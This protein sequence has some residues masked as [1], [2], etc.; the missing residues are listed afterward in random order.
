MLRLALICF[1]VGLLVSWY[2]VQPA[3]VLE[4][5]VRVTDAAKVVI[6][7]IKAGKEFRYGVFFVKNETV[8]DLES[9][10]SRTSTYNDYLKNLKVVK[11]TGKECRYGVL[12]FEFQ[13]KSSAD[14]KRD[15]LVLMSWCPDDVKVRSKFIHAASVEGM[16]KAVT[17]ISAFVQA[18]DDEQASLVEVQDKLTRTV[19]AC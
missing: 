8:I 12:D 14:K 6:D 4:S 1:S 10:G 16:K 7:K 3:A 5:G 15:K 18:S 17:G 19:T 9:T 11:P 2:P 13:C